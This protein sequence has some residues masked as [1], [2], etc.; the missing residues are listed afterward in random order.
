MQLI[1]HSILL[2]TLLTFQNNL[3]L[4][5]SVTFPDSTDIIHAIFEQAEILS[6]GLFWKSYN[7]YGMTATCGVLIIL[8]S[9]LVIIRK[10]AHGGQFQHTIF[11]LLM[12]L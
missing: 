9:M 3:F 10:F 12:R 2:S 8:C 11:S 5:L 7:V 6:R 4:S 1:F